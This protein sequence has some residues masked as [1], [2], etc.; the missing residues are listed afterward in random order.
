[1][2]KIAIVGVI[3]TL[4]AIQL[5]DKKEYASYI[6]IVCVALVGLFIIDK[7]K[8]VLEVVNRLGKF[9]EIES[10]YMTLLFK[11]IGITY[12]SEFSSQI[13]FDAGYGS[14]G[15]QIEIAAKF[16]ILAMSMPVVIKVLDVITNVLK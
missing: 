7:I 3:A 8:L 1:M 15:K 12:I 5:E 11:M 9:I 2:I 14:I 10:K 13:C 16:T 4:L 6:S